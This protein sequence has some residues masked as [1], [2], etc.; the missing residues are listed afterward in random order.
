MFRNKIGLMMAVATMAMV[1][2]PTVVMAQKTEANISGGDM[3]RRKLLYRSTRFE[4]APQIGFTMADSY[5]RNMLVGAS[6]MYHLTNEF[7]IGATGNFGVLQLATDLSDN[8]EQTLE[9]RNPASLAEL[10]YSFIQWQADL[11]LQY[12]PIFGK[13]TI[14]KSTTIN[15]DFHMGAGVTIVGEGVEAAIDGG[16]EDDAISGTKPGGLLQF[17]VRF[18]LSDMLSLN[19]EMKNLFY[20]Q[21]DISRG[22]ADSSFGNR[23]MLGAGVGIFFPGEVKISR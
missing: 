10:S 20:S 7:S 19:L 11:G 22:T 8:L 6:F 4:V 9:A 14:L 16:A 1:F 5:R 15:Y 13:F 21:A 17:G 18:Y 12:V 2:S 23:V 3:V